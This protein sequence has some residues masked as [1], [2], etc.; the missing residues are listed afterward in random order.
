M[1]SDAIRL[2]ATNSPKSVLNSLEDKVNRSKNITPNLIA[3][4]TKLHLVFLIFSIP[5]EELPSAGELM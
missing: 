2:L 1:V 5:V 4:E 3:F